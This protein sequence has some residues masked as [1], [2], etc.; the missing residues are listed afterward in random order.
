MGNVR[1]LDLKFTVFLFFPTK[2][3]WNLASALMI[4]DMEKTQ[5][6]SKNTLNF[7]LSLM[8][9]LNSEFEVLIFPL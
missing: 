2:G 8:L 7:R 1:V 5:I 6:G 3:M 9:C 4:V